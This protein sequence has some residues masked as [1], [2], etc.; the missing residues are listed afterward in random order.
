LRTHIVVFLRIVI[1]NGIK[2]IRKEEHPQDAEYDEE[3]DEDQKPQ[4]LTN[5]HATE[6]INIEIPY[7][8]EYVLHH[9][10]I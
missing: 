9:L 1:G 5:G 6:T 8:R 3:L 10:L 7:L 2:K 4:C